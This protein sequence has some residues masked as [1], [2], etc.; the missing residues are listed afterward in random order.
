MYALHAYMTISTE[1][2][3]IALGNNHQMERMILDLV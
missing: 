3:V 2:L 1:N